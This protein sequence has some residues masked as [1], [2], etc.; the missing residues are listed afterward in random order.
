MDSTNTPTRQTRGGTRSSLACLPCRSKH[1]KC[2]GKR[3][4]CSRCIEFEKQCDFAPSRRGGL[5][6]AALAERRKR[7]AAEVPESDS[8]G[9][10]T[11]RSEQLGQHQ[12]GGVPT[13]VQG[14]ELL[15][16]FNLLDGATL[17]NESA[18]SIS[19]SSPHSHAG[20]IETDPLIKS[21]YKSFHNLHPFLLPRAA[22]LRLV[23]DPPSMLN[24][25]PLIAVMRLIGNIYVTQEWS[26]SLKDQAE[27][28]LLQL[29]PDNPV[30][31]QYLLLYSIALF[32]SN[33][34]DEAKHHMD[35]A[36]EVA[37]RLGMHKSDFSGQYNAGEPVL[38]ESWRRTWWMLF[39]IDAYYA[40]TLGTMNF[41]VGNIEATVELPCEEREYESEAIP[42][43]KTLED[44]D[45]REF[46][47][48]TV[49]FSSFAYL[50]SAVRC[51]ALAIS[52]V[53]KVA[54]KE[55]SAQVIHS[56]DSTIDGWSLLLP[57]ER[58]NVMSKTGQIDELMFQANLLIG[59]A[60]I[61]LHRPLSDLRFNPVED[62]SSCAREPPVDNPSSDLINV[63][64]VRVL[65]AVESQIRL[66]A[67]PSRPFHHTPFTTCMVSEGTLALLSACN[68]LLQGK[69]LATARDQIR[70]TIGCLKAL[71]EFWP[72]T[73]KNVLEIQTIARHVL[74]LKRKTT[75]SDGT[76]TSNDATSQSGETATTGFGH[77]GSSNENGI[78]SYLG[79]MEDVCGWYNLGDL[80]SD[81]A[82][83]PEHQ[84]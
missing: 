13:Q 55:D 56:A 63:H 2:D 7:L 69:Q 8:N 36:T 42:P 78:L 31:V 67:L 62:V 17:G 81:F 30:L 10:S 72:R 37:E 57:K 27:E 64:T 45:S 51:A 73:A 9:T 23:K 40:G 32:W 22:F 61:G 6:R 59:V 5:D 66:L 79:S 18:Q 20:D 75:S 28:G 80:S 16:D 19:R 43:P 3:P 49:T 1:L 26:I 15:D 47:P 58:R 84:T 11:P 50:I 77:S 46:S 53:P 12:S 83:W 68:F 76:Q 14:W 34:K 82:Q 4:Q 48:E 29:S 74:G 41:R 24:F 44:F 39:I 70:L 33:F 52:T 71:G 25:G 38:E 35:C 54:S 65:R 21:Y 60:S